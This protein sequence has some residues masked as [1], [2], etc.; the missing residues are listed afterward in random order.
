MK[1]CARREHHRCSTTAV[2][3]A[4]GAEHLECVA[5]GPA[6]CVVFTRGVHTTGKGSKSVV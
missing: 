3:S 5:G 6:P 2:V 4:L 1:I